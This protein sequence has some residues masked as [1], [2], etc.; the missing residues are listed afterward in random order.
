[1]KNKDKT[2]QQK[3]E[4]YMDILGV[5]VP[6]TPQG[7]EIVKARATE[8]WKMSPQERHAAKDRSYNGIKR[9]EG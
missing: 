1:M 9:T 3:V 5:Y 2:I 7:A 8:D 4:E 6:D